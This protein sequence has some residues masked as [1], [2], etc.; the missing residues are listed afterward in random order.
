MSSSPAPSPQHEPT[1]EEILASIRKI[2]SEDQPEAAAKAPTP[3]TPLRAV[4]TDSSS[5]PASNA[6]PGGD[7]DVLDLT[8]ELPEEMPAPAAPSAAPAPALHD[9]IAFE[10]IESGPKAE[11]PPQEAE[12]ED[13]ISNTTRSMVSRAFANADKPPVQYTAPPLGTLDSIFTQAVQNAFQPT[14]K[15]WV[16]G[17]HAEIME[18]LKPLIRAWMDQH[19]PPLIEAVLARELGRAAADKVRSAAADKVR[20]RQI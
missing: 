6:A 18:S 12:P 19:L 14:L 8:E 4:P 11:E 5:A 20:A 1:M 2:I 15:D 16:D 9:D 13:L 10:T 17:H 3:P 7:A